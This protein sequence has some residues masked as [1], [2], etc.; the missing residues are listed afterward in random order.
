MMTD[1]DMVS[2]QHL[3]FLIMCGLTGSLLKPKPFSVHDSFKPRRKILFI[4]S[5]HLDV[6]VCITSTFIWCEICLCQLSMAL[7]FE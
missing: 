2:S 3:K 4:T 7:I 5:S 6:P 1:M